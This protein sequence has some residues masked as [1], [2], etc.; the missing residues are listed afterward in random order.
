MHLLIRGG[1]VV[2][3]KGLNEADVLIIG[4]KVT[5]VGRRLVAPQGVEILDASGKFVLPGIIDAH[6]HFGMKSRNGII[7]ADDFYR[8]SASA[9]CGGVTTVI[10]YAEPLPGQSLKEAAKQRRLEAESSIAVDF[11][12]HVVIPD[13]DGDRASELEALLH[14]GISSYKV[15]T[16]YEGLQIKDRDLR[17]L[18]QLA[19]ELNT[20]VTVH[21][22]DD[23]VLQDARHRLIQQARVSPGYHAASRPAEAEGRAVESMIRL[24]DE[25]GVLIYFVHISTGAGC[26]AI[27]RARAAGQRVLGET[28]PHYLLLTEELY[29]RPDA[30]KYI[31]CPPLRKAEDNWMLWESLQSGVLQ[32]V[33]TDHCAYTWD[34]KRSARTCFETP[35]GIPGSETLLPLLYSEGVARGRLT[36]PQLVALLS[37]NPARIFGLYP[38]KGGLAPGSDGD[39]V[40]LDPRKEVVL[41]AKNLHSAAGYTPFEG[42]RVQGYPET[43]I[44]RGKIVY[45]RGYFT[46]IQGGGRFVAA[47]LGSSF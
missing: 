18:L 31:M 39:A 12:L 44:L 30:Q 23:Q 24:A 40:I 11:S 25:T 26:R 36:L 10:D 8:G 37:A 3:E 38:R 19:R 9:A 15:F 6:T 1:T 22:E 4:G 47:G 45:H 14:Y 5:E 27:G 7:T 2:D 32:V 20:L 46:G 16:T 21:A 43:T 33:A 35:P 29:Q 28:C 34:Q 41:S 42:W 17:R 13:L